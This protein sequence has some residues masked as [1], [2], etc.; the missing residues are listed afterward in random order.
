MALLVY[1]ILSIAP[2]V[3]ISAAAIL[4]VFI[5]CVIKEGLS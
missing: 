4:I 2:F 3:M 1:L 5:G